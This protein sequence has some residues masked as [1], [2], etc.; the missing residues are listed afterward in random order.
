MNY[1]EELKS[2]DLAKLTLCSQHYPVT[3]TS[4]GHNKKIPDKY[5]RENTSQLNLAAYQKD[6]YH[7]SDEVMSDSAYANQ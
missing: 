1:S 6:Q 3:K 5:L 4:Q 7:D 2:K